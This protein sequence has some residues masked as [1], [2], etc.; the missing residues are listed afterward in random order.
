M[1][2]NVLLELLTPQ[3]PQDW[4]V[5][6]HDLGSQLQLDLRRIFLQPMPEHAN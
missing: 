3:A 5:L 1:D 4:N 6:F 2:Q